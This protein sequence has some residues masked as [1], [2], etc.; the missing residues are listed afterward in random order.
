M[1]LRAFS[2]NRY[3]SYIHINIPLRMCILGKF[4]KTKIL[5]KTRASMNQ[6]QQ[7]QAKATHLVD[8]YEISNTVLGLGINGKV[9][10]CTHRQ[11]NQKYALKVNWKWN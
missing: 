10:Q 5:K 8:D 2:T 4:F 3:I 11:T 9:V 1:I 7:R 6:T